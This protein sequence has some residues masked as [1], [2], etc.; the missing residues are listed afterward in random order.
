MLLVVDSESGMILG[1]ELLGPES[2]LAELWGTVPM[3]VVH[4]LARMEILPREI[5]VRSF[6]LLALLKLLEEELD[7]EVNS[8]PTLGS[9]EEAKEALVRRFV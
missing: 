6:Q 2:G 3:K 5:R 9:L 4:E 1:N 8:A 7:L